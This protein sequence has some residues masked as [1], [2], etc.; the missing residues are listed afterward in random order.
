[1]VCEKFS[2]MGCD[3]GIQLASTFSVFLFTCLEI[4][5]QPA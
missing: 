3:T 5:A 1:M 2:W 4:D